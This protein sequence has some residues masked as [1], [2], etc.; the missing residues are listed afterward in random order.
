MSRKLLL[1]ALSAA[2]PCAVAA[3]IVMPGTVK[4]VAKPV[5]P[6][7]VVPVT[8]VTTAPV[9]AVTGN[10]TIDVLKAAGIVNPINLEHPVT[11]SAHAPFI[12]DATYIH[13][14]NGDLYRDTVAIRGSSQTHP[15]D[16]WVHW[17]AFPD[18]RYVIDCAFTSDGPVISFTWDRPTIG[19]TRVPVT[20][21][22]AAAVLPTGTEGPVMMISNAPVQLS[23]CDI[24][25]FGS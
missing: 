3:Q 10:R 6:V 11:L 12:D 24:T 14:T 8:P 25:P 7:M 4:P 9:G 16:F 18:K 19:S 20:G 21:G 1:F 17:N 13:F 5:M 22:R 2:A 15:T 23:S